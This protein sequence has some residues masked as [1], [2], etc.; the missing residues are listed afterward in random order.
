MRAVLSAWRAK[1]TNQVFWRMPLPEPR[2]APPEGASTRF[3]L[4]QF[5]YRVERKSQRVRLEDFHSS[6]KIENS[7]FAP[8]QTSLAP[9]RRMDAS[10]YPEPRFRFSETTERV[11]SRP[12]SGGVPCYRQAKVVTELGFNGTWTAASWSS[13]AIVLAGP[14]LVTTS[15][16]WPSGF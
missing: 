8:R 2:R 13:R 10:Q 7:K 3:R 15:T 11:R 16:F 1:K 5:P 12:S 6:S 9:P 14:A 4:F